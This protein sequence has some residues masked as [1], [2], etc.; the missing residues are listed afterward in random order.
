[1][2][3]SPDSTSLR[4]PAPQRLPAPRGA[5]PAALA[6]AGAAAPARKRGFQPP[7]K[8]YI[9]RTAASYSPP[10]AA[11]TPQP[12]NRLSVLAVSLSPPPA[13]GCERPA[14]SAAPVP[15]RTLRRTPSPHR[16]SVPA[17]APR[18]RLSP[19]PP[20]PAV[21]PQPPSSPPHPRRPK[22]P[23]PPAA[24]PPPLLRPGCGSAQ[25]I[26]SAAPLA[27]AARAA[28]PVDLGCVPPP[29]SFSCTG[30]S[31]T[32]RASPRWCGRGTRSR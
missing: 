26:S 9:C 24:T 11:R 25:R 29:R 13:R 30:F 18:G 16:I 21:P 32:G 2:L 28:A 12:L 14:L 17:A 8:R 27:S 20:V 31:C 3:R 5:S 6:R 19:V 23:A 22:P 1:M 15:W 4:R 7:K 10:S